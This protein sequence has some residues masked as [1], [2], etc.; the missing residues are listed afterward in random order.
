MRFFVRVCK[1]SGTIMVFFFT[2]Q[3]T[4]NKPI[5]CEMRRVVKKM[6]KELTGHWPEDENIQE[7][8]A[9]NP[10]KLLPL[11]QKCETPLWCTN[12]ISMIVFTTKGP[13]GKVRHQNTFFGEIEIEISF[14]NEVLPPKPKT[15]YYVKLF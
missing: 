10:K 7:L 3:S 4:K 9:P 1:K 11:R 12:F 5:F 2:V 13:P 15:F 6:I 8:K 14:D